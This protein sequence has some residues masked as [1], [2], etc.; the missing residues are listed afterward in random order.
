MV[1]VDPKGR[2]LLPEGIRDRL[3]LTPG[4]EVEVHE[5]DGEVVIEPADCP[6]EIIERLEELVRKRFQSVGRHHRLRADPAQLLRS[7]GT[8]FGAEQIAVGD[9]GGLHL[10]DIG[11]CSTSECALP[12][13]ISLVQ[14][15][16]V[17]ANW[18]RPYQSGAS[19]PTVGDND[20]NL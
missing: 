14:G 16:V 8:L 7:I 1:K 11:D 19:G 15:D 17:A 5:E 3:G 6:E 20:S 13:E 4:T 18:G 12:L 2:I 10:F 9:A